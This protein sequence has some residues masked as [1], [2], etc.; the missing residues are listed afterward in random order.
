MTIEITVERKEKDVTLKEILKETL[1]DYLALCVTGCACCA[2]GVKVAKSRFANGIEKC[3]KVDPTL[4]TH[5]WDALN[6]VEKNSR[7]S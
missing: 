4:K 2:L 5:M 3:W 7:K 6:K 1:V